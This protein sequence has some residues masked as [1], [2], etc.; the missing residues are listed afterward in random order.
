MEMH[1]K[2]MIQLVKRWTWRPWLSDLE[3]TLWSHGLAYWVM[4]C[5]RWSTELSDILGGKNNVNSK[6]RT[7]G[8]Q[9]GTC[10]LKLCKFMDAQEGSVGV[11]SGKYS[12]VVNL[13]AVNWKADVPGMETVL[14]TQWSCNHGNMI[15][16]HYHWALMKSWQVA[17]N[18]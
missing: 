16:W 3:D 2:A 18:L 12:H 14:I 6:S 15:S 4:H 7:V 11:K 1:C 10:R 13:K 9:Q 17:D 5:M 8:T